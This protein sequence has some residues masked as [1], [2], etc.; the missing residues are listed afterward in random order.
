MS[1]ANAEIARAL[2]QIADLLDV[3]GAHPFR[4]RAYRRAARVIDT[5]PRSVT[6]MLAAGQDLDDLPGIG[7]DLAEKI[8]AEIDHLAERN[9]FLLASAEAAQANLAACRAELAEARAFISTM[10]DAPAEVGG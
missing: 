5:L 6:E 8:A 2:E 10:I 7:K 3:E 4:I 1:V 9:A